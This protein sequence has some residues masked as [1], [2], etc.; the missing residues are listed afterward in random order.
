VDD[1]R[2]LKDADL[3]RWKTCFSKFKLDRFLGE[4]AH[5]LADDALLLLDPWQA[6]V[7]INLH[8]T[9]DLLLLEDQWEWGD[10]FDGTALAAGIAAIVTVSQPGD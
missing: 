9:D 3:T 6:A 10:G 1:Y 7:L 2:A 5:L 4:W 8:S